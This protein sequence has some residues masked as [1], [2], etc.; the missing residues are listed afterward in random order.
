MKKWIVLAFLLFPSIAIAQY[1]QSPMLDEMQRELV[2]DLFRSQPSPQLLPQVRSLIINLRQENQTLRNLLH[3]SYKE[4]EQQR[5]RILE[6]EERIKRL[7]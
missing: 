4:L 5:L 1:P 6:L 7:E 3:Q 2:R